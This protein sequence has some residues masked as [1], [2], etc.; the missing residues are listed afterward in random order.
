MDVVAKEI[1][2]AQNGFN[3]RSCLKIE[4][5]FLNEDIIE[6]RVLCRIVE[7]ILSSDIK[8]WKHEIFKGI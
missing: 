3:F 5:D 2:L 8:K 4:K 6:E 7:K 1:C